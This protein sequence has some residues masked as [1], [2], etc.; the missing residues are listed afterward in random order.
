MGAD[1]V[2]VDDIPVDNSLR[3]ILQMYYNRSLTMLW[4]QHDI[5]IIVDTIVVHVHVW[6]NIWFI[7]VYSS[8]LK[9]VTG[10]TILNFTLVIAKIEND[11]NGSYMWLHCT[12]KIEN[13]VVY[14]YNAHIKLRMTSY[15]STLYI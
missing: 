1:F 11:I 14:V 12:Y 8:L 13:D 9:D 4:S 5:I 6:W 10:N 7:I 15:M 3:L 2:V